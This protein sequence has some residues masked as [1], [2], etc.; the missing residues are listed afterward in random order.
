MTDAGRLERAVKECSALTGQWLEAMMAG[1]IDADTAR[2][3]TA[4]AR[5]I[6]VQSRVIARLLGEVTGE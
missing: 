3:L 5:V 6:D 4:A 1:S 2:V